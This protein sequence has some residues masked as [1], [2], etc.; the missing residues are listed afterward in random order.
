MLYGAKSSVI[1]LQNLV[2]I[3]Q[4][5]I[6]SPRPL[7]QRFRCDVLRSMSGC[8]LDRIA[9]LFL[10][11][12]RRCCM[13]GFRCNDTF[14]LPRLPCYRHTALHSALQSSLVMPDDRHTAIIYYAPYLSKSA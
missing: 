11:L 14:L 3:L 4:C 2:A 6:P 9:L 12:I 13:F 1:R 8:Q 10:S 7:F 5:P